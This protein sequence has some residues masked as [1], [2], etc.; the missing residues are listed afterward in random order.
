M[1]GFN[2]SSWLIPSFIKQFLVYW[3]GLVRV[4]QW[5]T[6]FVCTCVATCVWQ[7]WTSMIIPKYIQCFGIMDEQVSSVWAERRREWR[8]Q[9]NEWMLMHHDG[10]DA[11]LHNIFGIMS[12]FV[13]AGESLS[14]VLSESSHQFH[15]CVLKWCWVHQSPSPT[16]E[17][18]GPLLS[19]LVLL[20]GDHLACSW[21]CDYSTINR[22]LSM[23][24]V[25]A[26]CNAL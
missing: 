14:F 10:G 17:A 20:G 8:N 2:L 21:L 18:W 11:H 15:N 22:F 3:R 16:P 7:L 24:I 9:M 4:Y 23:S 6:V 13:T 1:F 5:I 26:L 19:S 25:S 12:I